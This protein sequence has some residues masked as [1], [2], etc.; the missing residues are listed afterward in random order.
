[1]SVYEWFEIISIP[2]YFLN[3]NNEKLK[4]G[5]SLAIDSTW[6]VQKVSELLK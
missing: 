6:S 1:M 5:E 3:G 2:L 4:V